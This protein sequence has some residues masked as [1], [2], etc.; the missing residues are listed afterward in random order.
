VIT[1]DSGLLDIPVMEQIVNQV[2]QLKKQGIK[3]I[4]VSSGAMGAGRSLVKISEDEDRVVKRQVLAAVGQVKLMQTYVDL[5]VKHGLNCAQVLAT[6][7]DFRDRRHYLNMKNCFEALL[8]DDIIPI[9][10]ENDVVSVDELMFTDNDELAGLIASMMS[11]EAVLLLSL[12]GGILRADGSVVAVVKDE[13]EVSE[14]I[15]PCVS[16][17]GR[18]GMHTKCRIALKLAG[19]GITT[20]ILNGR[21]AGAI[22]DALSGKKV[23]TKFL[24]TGDKVSNVKKWIAYAEGQEKGIV[25]INECAEPVLR[26]KGK[27]RSLLPVGITKVEGVFEKGD[28]I[29]IKNYQGKIIGFGRAEYG[30]DLAKK[31]MGKKGNRELVHYDYLFLNQ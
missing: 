14:H 9:V 10:N 25:H 8:R 13:K 12:V 23:G 2:A 20:H 3:I 16:K 30:S 31:N 28:I 17:F 22:I 18:G 24:A 19:L 4:I 15:L 27:A 11:V 29:K 7:S 5:F 26:E 1:N 6:K 21:R